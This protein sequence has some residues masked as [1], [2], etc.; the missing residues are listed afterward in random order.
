MVTAINATLLHIHAIINIVTPFP[1]VKRTG[2]YSLFI[3]CLNIL[4]TYY[5]VMLQFFHCP[6]ILY[7]NEASNKEATQ[8][9]VV[10]IN[11][12][13][14]SFAIVPK[15]SIADIEQLHCHLHLHM[16]AKLIC[17]VLYCKVPHMSKCY[18]MFHCEDQFQRPI[19]K[20]AF[21]DQNQSYPGH[22]EKL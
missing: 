8:T 6:I 1:S 22:H 18:A 10:S 17:K 12:P 3:E 20:H 15:M 13:F 14:F 2:N 7:L 11:M 19:L 4:G 5:I 9:H 16:S 21:L